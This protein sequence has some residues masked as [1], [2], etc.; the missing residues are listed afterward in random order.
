MF[1][2]CEKAIAV[3]EDDRAREISVSVSGGAD[4][5]LIV[6]MVTKIRPDAKFVWFNT[7][8]EYE[9]T[10]RHLGYL[11]NR[12]GIKIKRIRAN[13]PVP[14]AV[15]K[16]GYP[17]FAKQVSEYAG[18]LQRHGFDWSDRPFEELLAEYPK[19][20]SALRWWCNE[21]GDGSRFN[22]AQWKYLKEFMMQNPPTFP[23]S[24]GCCKGAKKDTAHDFMKRHKSNLA[25]T[26][27]RKYEGGARG[28]TSS[29]FTGAYDN[30][31]AVFRPIFWLK[32][33]DKE[34]YERIFDIRH[35]E[36]Y[37][38]Y[39]LRR[40]GCVGCPFGRNWEHELEVAKQYEPK[41]YKACTK[42]FAPSYEYT[43]A[44]WKF[45]KH[46]EAEAKGYEQLSLFD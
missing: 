8:M 12:Y 38:G 26:G 9:A 24:T 6:D 5:D 23:I 45:R 28:G 43:R 14:L 3:L 4:S 2:A 33:S 20:K 25:I 15:R 40:T 39:G 46:K 34:E 11:E 30:G 41:L 27:E 1:D 42:V 13:Y 21:K 18:R 37:W 32:D 19:C 36:C 16:F 10:K 22:I 35:S 7:G 44:Y 31:S 17:V 29:C